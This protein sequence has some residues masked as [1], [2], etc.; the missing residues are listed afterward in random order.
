MK[1]ILIV[2]D[3]IPGHFNQSKGV[4]LMLSETYECNIAIN[5]ICSCLR[6]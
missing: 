2:S 4:A 5:E 6:F 1:K 3:G